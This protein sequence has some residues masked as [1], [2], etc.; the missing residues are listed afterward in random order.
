M[1]DQT[2][3][4]IKRHVL[5][6]WD[7]GEGGG[8]LVCVPLLDAAARLCAGVDLRA[9]CTAA[10]RLRTLLCVMMPGGSGSPTKEKSNEMFEVGPSSKL[11]LQK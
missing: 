7:V 2:W 11:P 8:V 9:V 10:E 6:D 4:S 1:C 3:V 5:A